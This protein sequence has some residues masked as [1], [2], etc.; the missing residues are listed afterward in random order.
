LWNPDPLCKLGRYPDDNVVVSR[1]ISPAAWT[2]AKK[3]ILR[4]RED[5]TGPRSLMSSYTDLNI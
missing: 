1:D 4:E 2:R 3:R 5:N